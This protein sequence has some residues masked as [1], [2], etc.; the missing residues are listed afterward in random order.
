[1]TIDIL[2]RNFGGFTVAFEGRIASIGVP[3]TSGEALAAAAIAEDER[4]AERI[5]RNRRLHALA[6]EV[7]RLEAEAAAEKRNIIRAKR[8]LKAKLHLGGAR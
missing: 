8:A 1:M 6:T 3:D 7:L 5:F 4:L 2:H